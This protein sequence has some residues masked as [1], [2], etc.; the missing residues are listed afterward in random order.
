M[1]KAVYHTSDQMDYVRLRIP[2]DVK[3]EFRRSCE[4]NDQT[5]SAVLL[6]FITD[7]IEAN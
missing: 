3:E 7:Y 6:Q 4:K 1:K 2:K 5:M